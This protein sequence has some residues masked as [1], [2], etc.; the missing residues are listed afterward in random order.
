MIESLNRHERLSGGR[1]LTAETEIR[2]ENPVIRSFIKGLP[3]AA[4]PAY[5][6][7]AFIEGIPPDVT[8]RVNEA[9]AGAYREHPEG[10][11]ILLDEDIRVYAAGLRGFVYAAC[12]LTR[13]AEG[14]FIRQGVVYNRPLAEIRS[15]KL[16]L[17]P[18]ENID[19]F[20]AVVDLCCHYRCNTLIVE[21]GGAMEYKRH[22]EINEGWLAYCAEMHEY[23]GKTTVIQEQTFPWGKNSIHCE[24]GGGKFLSQAQVRDIVGYCNARG[25]D[26]IP[27]MP[28]LSHCDYLLTRHREFAERQDDPYADTYCP[29]APGLYDY[30]FDVLDEVVDVFRPRAMHIGH[31]ELYTVG[32]CPR[33]RGRSAPDIYA[34]DVIRIHDHLASRGVRT[35]IWS[36]KLLNSVAKNGVP[37]GG[38][39]KP[40]Y[41]N[42]EKALTIPATYPAIE[43]VPRDILCMHWYW[44]IVE[45]WDA[46][47]L[48]RGFAMF[49]GNFDPPAMPHAAA[50]IAAGALGGGPSNWSYATFPYL[51]ENGALLSLAYASLLFWKDGMADDAYAGALRFC[52]W[53]LFR[54]RH[55]D[56]LRRPRVEL[57]HTT[58]HFRPYRYHADGVFID[59]EADT[60]GKY[61]VEYEDGS[62]FEVPVVYGQNIV[63]RDRRWTRA[64]GAARME[65]GEEPDELD[66]ECYSYDKLL[67]SAAWSTLPFEDGGQTWYRIVVEN[68]A[69]GRRIRAVR[70]VEKPGME[71][72]V[73]VRD[74]KIVN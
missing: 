52:F 8:G 20:K 40:Y 16:Y 46:E 31:D 29:N 60:L 56:A 30:V 59:Y 64:Y 12:D 10:Y 25:V 55:A 9:F 71:G 15:L 7:V 68:P 34:D 66:C 22:P 5:G 21:V 63:N 50:R 24:N 45:A 39:E 4:D 2:T 69:P 61:V 28:T 32:I 70:L 14:G 67:A 13:M 49:Y 27:E 47:F 38:A 74:I 1:Y 18:E 37:V 62:S 41:F 3:D 73:F 23:S 58:S 33:C 53:D 54:F 57:A 26:V 36:E 51:Q 42:G 11:V 19:A 48:R 43:R 35:V 17:P 6:S 65:M 44:S 72:K